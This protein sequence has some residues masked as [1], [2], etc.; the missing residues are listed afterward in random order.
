MGRNDWLEGM[1][2]F[3]IIIGAIAV[4]FLGSAGLA[5]LAIEKGSWLIGCGAFIWFVAG[6]ATGLTFIFAT[7]NQEPNDP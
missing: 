4:W 7:T 5:I 6:G 1:L 2:F 3:S